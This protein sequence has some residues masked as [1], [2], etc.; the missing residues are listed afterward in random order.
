M[1]DAGRHPN[2]ELLSYSEVVDVHGYVGNFQVKVTQSARYVDEDK[3]TGCGDCME[4]CVWQERV[5]SE[6]EA[7]MGM[8]KRGLIPFAQAVPMKAVIDPRL[9]SRHTRGKC[10]QSAV[11]VCEADAIDFE[12]KD[13]F[14]DLKVGAVV[15]ATAST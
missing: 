9:L 8:R 1:M 2:I 6:Y 15:L 4:A 7:G 12:Q 14:I 10:A 3:C 5:Y 11:Q 13:E